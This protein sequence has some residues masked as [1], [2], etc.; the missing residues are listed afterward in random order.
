M[1]E[2][3]RRRFPLTKQVIHQATS[4]IHFAHTHTTYIAYTRTHKKMK[5]KKLLLSN[6]RG[7]LFFRRINIYSRAHALRTQQTTL[8]TLLS[9]LF[10]QSKTYIMFGSLAA[11]WTFSL[12]ACA[13]LLRLYSRC[14]R[15]RTRRR[16]FFLTSEKSQRDLRVQSNFTNCTHCAENNTNTQTQ[17]LRPHKSPNGAHITYYICYMPMP[18]RV[19]VRVWMCVYVCEYAVCISLIL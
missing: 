1:G 4:N 19:R 12:R 10:L 13:R 7:G 9:K 18:Y 5:K 15:A 3:L 14:A 6:K 2:L 8:T 11:R 16:I 17:T